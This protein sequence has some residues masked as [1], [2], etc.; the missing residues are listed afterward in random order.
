MNE[1]LILKLLTFYM[2]RSALLK[3]VKVNMFA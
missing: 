1:K 2:F 3:N